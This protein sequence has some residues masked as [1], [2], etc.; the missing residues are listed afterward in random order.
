M[1][2]PRAHPLDPGGT[3]MAV[4]IACTPTVEIT[5]PQGGRPTVAALFA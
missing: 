5:R 4:P 3:A 1:S 2:A